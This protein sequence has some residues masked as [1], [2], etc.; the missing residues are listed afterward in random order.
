MKRISRVVTLMI[1]AAMMS[2]S[3][4]SCQKIDKPDQ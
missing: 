1:A 4:V 3:A 2:C